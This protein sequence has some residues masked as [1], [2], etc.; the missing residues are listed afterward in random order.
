MSEHIPGRCPC[1]NF[2][3]RSTTI[4]PA[5]AFGG[6]SQSG[7]VAQ[8]GTQSGYVMHK[9]P[10]CCTACGGDGWLPSLDTPAT[11]PYCQG[12][13][14][15]AGAACQPCKDAHAAYGRRPGPPR[16]TATERAIQAEMEATAAYVRPAPMRLDGCTC[17]AIAGSHAASCQWAM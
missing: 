16:Y 7:R 17:R 1:G 3:G 13:G 10:V 2:H 5:G 4:K 14:K 15:V 9:R 6:N 12:S 8:H 11:C